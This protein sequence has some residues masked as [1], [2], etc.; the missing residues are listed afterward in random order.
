MFL[1]NFSLRLFFCRWLQLCG[2]TTFPNSSSSATQSFSFSAKRTINSLSSTS[3]TIPPCFLSGGS[4]SNLLR[5]DHVSPYYK[6]AKI[7]TIL[8]LK[9]D[10]YYVSYHTVINKVK[11]SSN[12]TLLVSR[13]QGNCICITGNF[14]CIL[15]YSEITCYSNLSLS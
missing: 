1:L 11:I 3:T 6:R 14:K 4:E 10:H 15:F 7:L 8:V 2:G 9:I 13:F 5:E 12:L